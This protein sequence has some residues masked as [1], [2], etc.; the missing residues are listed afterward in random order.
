MNL[1]WFR[2]TEIT[3]FFLTFFQQFWYLSSKVNNDFDIWY[4]S[5]KTSKKFE[6][7]IYSLLNFH[8]PPTSENT[9]QSN[10]WSWL[11][12]NIY[13]KHGKCFVKWHKIDAY[14]LCF[15][16]TFLETNLLKYDIFSCT[17]HG[18]RHFK[19]PRI[20]IRSSPIYFQIRFAIAFFEIK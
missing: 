7:P 9:W 2:N 3:V 19:I 8:T 10:N 5:K 11:T 15:V 6:C 12:K 14:A 20:I 16:T 17:F 1:F 18:R 4:Y 13:Q